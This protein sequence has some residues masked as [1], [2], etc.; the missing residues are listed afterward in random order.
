MAGIGPLPAPNWLPV[1]SLAAS[2]PGIPTDPT[3]DGVEPP[4]GAARD[5]DWRV[6]DRVPAIGRPRPSVAP[7]G[8]QVNKAGGSLSIS[9]PLG[10]TPPG[11]EP[12]PLRGWKRRAGCQ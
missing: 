7:V 10:L 12:P 3:N 8:A 6:S 1:H 4:K 5:H 2:A 11:Y 9:P